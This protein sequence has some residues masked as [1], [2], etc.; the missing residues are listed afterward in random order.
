MRYKTSQDNRNDQA[1]FP[2]KASM[3]GALPA[4]S[5]ESRS[6]GQQTQH[7]SWQERISS[8]A[9]HHDRQG[10]APPSIQVLKQR[11]AAGLGITWLEPAASNAPSGAVS[12]KSLRDAVKN[13]SENSRWSQVSGAGGRD[14]ADSAVGWAKSQHGAS[15]KQDVGGSGLTAPLPDWNNGFNEIGYGMTSGK[16]VTDDYA[17]VKPLG[18]GWTRANDSAS[19]LGK[20]KSTA[21]I[22]AGRGWIS[23]HP[24]SRESSQFA[25]PPQSRIVLPSETGSKVV[26]T[27]NKQMSYEQWKDVQASSYQAPASAHGTASGRVSKMGASVVGEQ[28]LSVAQRIASASQSQHGSQARSTRYKPAAVESV[29]SVPAKSRQQA[30]SEYSTRTQLL[31]AHSKSA[32]HAGSGWAGSLALG[33]LDGADDE[34]DTTSAIESWAYG[35][36]LEG[37]AAAGVAYNDFERRTSGKQTQLRM[38]WDGS[39]L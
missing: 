29:T 6:K 25:S 1:R 33:A 21:T 19:M 15:A 3:S 31:E 34:P 16:N 9:K 10:Y 38:P 12:A 13:I 32:S 14:F 39:V 8:Q 11:S 22:F 5:Q 26:G 28:L 4:K 18:A 2:A 37:I 27:H 35:M 7:Q 30:T 20:K 36:H 24:L 17:G 23:P